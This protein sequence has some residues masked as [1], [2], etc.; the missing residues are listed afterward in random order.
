MNVITLCY[1]KNARLGAPVYPMKLLYIFEVPAA[2]IR[3]PR[4]G[5]RVR[6]VTENC[7]INFGRILA[8]RR[9]AKLTLT[10]RCIRQ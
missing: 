8:D 1:S 6:L 10:R 3:W 7:L 2:F 9:Q 5:L 4:I